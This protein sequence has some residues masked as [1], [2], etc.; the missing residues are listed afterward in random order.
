MIIGTIAN[1]RL[2]IES[3]FLKPAFFG[4]FIFSKAKPPYQ[5]FFVSVYV[6]YF[7]I[8]IHQL[9]QDYF[10]ALYLHPHTG[11]SVAL[12]PGASFFLGKA[13]GL[14]EIRQ[15]TGEQLF[16]RGGVGGSFKHTATGLPR[17]LIN[18]Q[19]CKAKKI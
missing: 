16:M 1:I 15:N 13:D 18:P 10:N 7:T 3:R 9:K 5:Q 17:A 12:R 19:V 6:F 14:S 4:S 8:I 2:T 11:E